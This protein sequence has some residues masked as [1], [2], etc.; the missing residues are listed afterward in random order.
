MFWI[1]HLVIVKKKRK[2]IL[3]FDNMQFLVNNFGESVH[4]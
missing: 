4:V 1:N 3:V 2:I